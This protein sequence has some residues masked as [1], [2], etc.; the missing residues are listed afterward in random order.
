MSVKRRF[1]IGSEIKAASK[2][3][4]RRSIKFSST[5]WFPQG[6]PGLRSLLETRRRQEPRKSKVKDLE[7]KAVARADNCGSHVGAQAHVTVCPWRL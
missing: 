4:H 7:G 3:L 5:N 1:S 6:C 2:N